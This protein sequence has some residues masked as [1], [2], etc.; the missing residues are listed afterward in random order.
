MAQIRLLK[1]SDF[2]KDTI[3]LPESLDEERL[4]RSI[5]E[6]QY[7]DLEPIMGDA[8]FS[9][10]LTV[11]PDSI[12]GLTAYDNAFPYVGGTTYYVSYS[13]TIYKFIASVTQTGVLPDS[14]PAIWEEKT[15]VALYNAYNK[16]MNGETYTDLNNRSIIFPGLKI[17]LIYWTYS[18]FIQ[19]QQR[20]V[21]SHGYAMKTSQHSEPVEQKDIASDKAHFRAIAASYWDKVVKYLTVKASTYPLWGATKTQDNYGPVRINAIGG[22]D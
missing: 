7:T 12:T 11:N 15:T 10:L 21:T 9:E 4:I 13:G 22:D 6:A 18:N 20:T 2:T 5:D 3:Y 14:D 17:A 16:L 8:F 1:Q 19:T